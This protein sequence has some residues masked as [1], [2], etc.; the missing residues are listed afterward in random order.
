MSIKP[1]KRRRKDMKKEINIER[2][3]ENPLI[4]PDIGI[5]W[6]SLNAFNPGVIIGDDGIYRMLVRG[7][8]TP[9]QVG[10]DLGLA[11]SNDGINWVISK[12]PVLQCGFNKYCTMGIEDP[13]IVKWIDGFYYV[14]TTVCSPS[15]I[16][17]G[18]WKTKDFLRHHFE[19][20]GIPFNQNDKDASIFPEPINGLAYLLHRTDIHIWI[21]RTN[22][23]TLKTGW[24][25]SRI[26]T[27][28]D[29]WYKSPISGIVPDK[30]GIA[31][32]P[33][34]TPGGWLVITHVVHKKGEN[35]YNR[36]YSLG[37]MLL[38]SDDPTIVEYIHPKP[39]LWPET[40]YE[41]NGS[42]PI[43]CFCNAIVDPDP[44]N[45]KGEF[46]LYYG[47]ADTSICGGK[48]YKKDL[49]MCY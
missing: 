32:P 25:R 2:F 12:E 29:E 9:T 19:W 1:Q 48:L 21:S 30:I 31:G 16:M 6:M 37:L 39:I 7:A 10:S 43:V 4:V 41:L 42:V 27:N 33:I 24:R 46:H 23:M 28:K 14:L 18:M 5:K 36:A 40:N 11:I 22:D 44:G 17:I 49:P 3:K 38:N 45:D 13:R 26:L 8:W 20:V 15:D 35:R 34:R 47:S